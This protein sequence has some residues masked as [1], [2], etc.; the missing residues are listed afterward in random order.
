MAS[1][2]LLG[3]NLAGAEFGSNVPGVFGTDYTYPTHAE[4]DYYASKGLGV[5]RLPF[6]W[7]RMQHSEFGTLDP[8]EL[9][10]LT[11]VVNYATGK[12]L[13]IEIE[14]HDY[15]YGFGALIGSAQTPN[16]AFADFWGK[17]AQHFESNPNVIFGLMNEPHDQSATAWLGSANA[18]IAAI[19]GAGTV[20]QE[21]LV[22][23]SYWD[24]AWTWTSTDNAAVVGTGVQDPA[25]N[26]AFEVH[27]YLD[28]DGSGTHPGA[29]SATIGV[30]RLTAITQW[31]E[32]TGNHLFL[33]EVGVTTDQTSLT[34]LDGMLTHMQQH[35][36]AW[37]GETYWAGGPW[38][39]NYMFS[40]EPQNGV[41]K[42][43]MAILVQHLAA[44]GP[45]QPPPVGTS[46]DMILRRGDGTYEIYDI[47]NS[48]VLAAYQL[49][50]VGTEWTV[51]GLGNFFGNDTTDMILRDS[52]NGAFE[53]YDI[54]NNN[55]TNAA[56]LGQ[57]GLEWTVAG[58]GNF[59]SHAGE[60][61][62]I[63]RNMNTGEFEVYDIS[64]NKVTNA[65]P[66]GAVGLE[67]TV[68]GFGNF[69][70]LG[71]S[72]MILRNMNTGG[73]EVYDI[74][75][76]QITNAAFMGAVGLEWT[77][78]GFGDFSSRPGE[79]DMI[80]RNTKTGGL[81]VYDISNNQV[82]SAAFM[83]TVG[84]EWQFAGIGPI[85]AAGA[86]DLVLRNTNTGA[87]EAYDI[88]NNQ[89]TG[90]S[91][92]GTVGLDWQASGFAVDPPTASIGNSSQVGQLVQAMAGFADGSVAAESLNP[93]VLGADTS[94]QSF[95]TTPQ[96]A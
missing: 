82:A 50:Q 96:H 48:S 4:I 17:L 73:F 1:P 95:L 84:L 54:S 47:G 71:E 22:P 88:A 66:M 51:A 93:V 81:E 61:D 10:R 83:G 62:M 67:W 77:V 37:Q 3:V 31:A 25:H 18:A 20:S 32:A 5:I 16:S 52:N 92:L 89:I 85:H 30:E 14:P 56:S 70:S 12:G 60:T 21:I 8:T 13:K 79:T 7:E 76:N 86:S 59:S 94:Q 34:A 35:T 72:D 26:F 27:Q 43:Q 44:S 49:G 91:N 11:D 23:G 78:S 46:A 58:F 64:N 36:D 42:P 57:V 55:V 53:V 75:N 2:F 15:G 65:A 39:G 40:I 38:W 87:F 45:N 80:M 28:S 74:S 24:G 19:R 68:A 6:L 33:G 69:S 29:V 41:D 63:L 90:A 9:S